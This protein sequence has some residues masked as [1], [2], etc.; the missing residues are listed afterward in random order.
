MPLSLSRVLLRVVTALKA[1]RIPCALAG[2]FAANLWVRREEVRETHDID[3]SV[4]TLHPDPAG[5]VLTHLHRYG[6]HRTER[7]VDVRLRRAEFR[8]ILVDGVPVDF[9]LP[10]NKDFAA[11]AFR[12]IRPARVGRTRIQALSPEDVFLFKALAGREK[13]VPPMAALAERPG[14]D[15]RY[16]ERWARRLGVWRFAKRCL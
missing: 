8:R 16:V 9:V 4:L 10:R 12:R 1:G 13:D 6:F 2:G 7:Q 15:R 14:F 5:E 11:A 3:F